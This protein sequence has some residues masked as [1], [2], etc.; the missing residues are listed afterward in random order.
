M[1]F[2]DDVGEAL[3][4]TKTAAAGREG[5][6]AGSA[7]SAAA[8][9]AAGSASQAASGVGSQA[10][11]M[12]TQALAQGR[13]YDQGAAQSMGANAADYLGKARADAEGAASKQA[14][15]ASTQGTQA[16]LRASRSSGLN[17]GQAAL[18]SGQ[19]AAG[20]YQ[21][22]LAQGTQQG[23]Q[24]YMGAAGQF[25]GQ[26]AEMAGRANAGIQN[27]LGATGQQLNAA[28]AQAQ[29][30]QAQ[31]AI[32]AQ[33]Q[34]Q[35]NQTAQTTWG[36]IG[37]VAGAVAPMIAS[38]VNV[39]KNIEGILDKVGIREKKPAS[40]LDE[41]LR[42]IDPVKFDYQNEPDGTDHIG[43]IAQQVEDSPLKNAVVDTPQ[44]KALNTAELSASYLPIIIEMATRIKALEGK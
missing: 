19:Q 29:A 28:Q 5:V 30:A 34:A 25:A 17:A 23:I 35:A 15:Q 38:D 11:G 14:Q 33:Q 36:A 4:G 44:G 21:N 7:G 20:T 13:G 41:I 3:F 1:G 9:R 16:A 42:K 43:T 18:A 22:A 31:A 32:G 27:Q 6:A 12:T 10:Q 24:N 2:W 26:G 8:S 40:T 37:N 39:K